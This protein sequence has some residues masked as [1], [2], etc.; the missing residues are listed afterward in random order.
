MAKVPAKDLIQFYTK[1]IRPIL[2]YSAPVYHYALPQYLQESLERIQIRALSI[3]F[4]EVSY[5]DSVQLSCLSSLSSRH[6]ELCNKLFSSV[7]A[8]SNHK[9]YNH[10]Y[11]VSTANYNLRCLQTYDL[12]NIKTNRFLNTFIP[13][14]CKLSFLLLFLL[15]LD[16]CHYVK[17]NIFSLTHKSRLRACSHDPEV[18]SI[19]G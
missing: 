14:S 1:C 13:S 7:V 9:L 15:I 2:D 18:A 6:Q 16:I 10:L 5:Q 11:K 8:N 19:P 12:P 17:S 3:I 4:P